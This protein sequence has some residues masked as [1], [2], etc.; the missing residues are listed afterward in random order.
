MN[1]PKNFQKTLHEHYAIIISFLSSAIPTWVIVNYASAQEAPKKLPL[2]V[3]G[4][5]QS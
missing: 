1:Q 5:N 2:L 3:H 4:E